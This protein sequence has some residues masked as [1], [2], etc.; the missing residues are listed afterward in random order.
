MYYPFNQ[1]KMK[2]LKVLGIILLVIVIVVAVLAF[3]APT[4]MET[5]RSVKIDAPKELI[6]EHLVYFEAT[7]KW[8]P[9]MELDSNMQTNI[10]GEDGKVGTVFSWEGNKDAGKG[11]QE[12]TLIDTNRIEHS[13]TFIEPFESTAKTYFELEKEADGVEVSWGFESEMVRP[14]NVLGLFM[15]MEDAIGDDYE[16]GLNKLK[17]MVEKAN[18][19]K[20]ENDS[21]YIIEKIN[22]EEKDYLTFR[23]RV[24]FSEMQK[25]Y[26]ENLGAMF[27]L[28][29]ENPSTE[30]AGAAS[31]IYYDWDE[32][33]MEADLAATVPF[34]ST[35]EIDFEKYK[36]VSLEGEALKIAYYGEYDK[37][38][39]KNKSCVY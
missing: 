5:E 25:F 13:I 12:L 24:S 20:A 11:K 19:E 35:D 17:E 30:I 29:N 33:N 7:N 18:E 23:D 14:F 28:L 37:L 4:E 22:F 32:E 34:S 21:E 10:E 26:S 39:I 36:V 38:R 6:Y 16:K 8:S 15:S 3:V 31:G 27:K 2:V 9:W 1:T